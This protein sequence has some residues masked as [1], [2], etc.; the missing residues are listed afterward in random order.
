VQKYSDNLQEHQF[1]KNLKLSSLTIIS[2]VPFRMLT[3]NIGCLFVGGHD[4]PFA[5]IKL[6]KALKDYDNKIIECSWNNAKGEWT[7]M[8][9]R[10]D[11]SFPNS[12]PT[13]Q[14]KE[15]LTA[16]IFPYM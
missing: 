1:N 10:T 7:F 15:G 3:T 6:T 4:L 13:A 8:R 9:E 16:S 12:L 5:E 14:C 11:K 2:F